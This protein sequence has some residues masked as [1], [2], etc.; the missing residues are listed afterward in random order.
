[1]FGTPSPV[2]LPFHAHFVHQAYSVFRPAKETGHHPRSSG[3]GRCQHQHERISHTPSPACS[4]RR[5]PPVYGTPPRPW[6]QGRRRCAGRSLMARS[7]PLAPPRVHAHLNSRVWMKA[8]TSSRRSSR[9]RAK[10]TLAWTK[11]ARL[12]QS[13]R[14]PSKRKPWNGAS[15]II[16]AMASVS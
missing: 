7:T 5:S 13:K 10:A 2:R 4:R 15:P 9:A 8:A 1:M 14:S 11:P 6:S 12:P 3:E 16:A